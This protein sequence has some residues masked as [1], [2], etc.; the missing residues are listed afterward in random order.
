MINKQE[1]VLI[2][3][4]N[5]NGISDTMECLRSIKEQDYKDIDILVIDNGSRENPEREIKKLDSHII[6]V[7]NEENTGFAAGYNQGIEWA[8]TKDYDYLF[9]VNNDT[10]LASDCIS[11]LVVR[12]KQHK[13]KAVI[14]PSIL[15]Y[16]HDGKN[17]IIWSEGAKIN[18]LTGRTEHINHMMQYVFKDEV[19]T[20]D[21]IVGCALFLPNAAA[22][23]P[24]FNTEYFAFYEDVDCSFSL[25]KK[26]YELLVDKSTYIHHKVSATAGY[27]S[28]FSI[29]LQARNKLLFMKKNRTAL[30]YMAF[31]FVLILFEQFYWI[32]FFLLKKRADLVLI[33]YR[34][35]FDGIKGISGKPIGTFS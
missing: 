11:K 2:I 15:Y 27:L 29:Y 34:G 14:T 19:M 22:T 21:Y 3:I 20:V 26:G 35:L 4:L 30:E 7:R 12:E 28:R 31:L 25:K 5:W 18:L 16:S 10:V 9:L 1:S 23:N 6:F 33:S 17:S 8:K 32:V 13:D 24:F